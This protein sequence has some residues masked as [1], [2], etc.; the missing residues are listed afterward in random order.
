VSWSNVFA[1]II[2]VSLPM[3]IFY[4]IFQRYILKAQFIGAIK[5]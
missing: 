3:L 4:I 1:G 5:G 2:L